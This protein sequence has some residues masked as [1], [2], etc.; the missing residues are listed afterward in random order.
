[1]NNYKRKDGSEYIEFAIVTPLRQ[2]DGTI[3]HYV[4]V[5]EDITEKKRIGQELDEY[6]YHL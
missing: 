6:R 4:A 5:K 2:P 3:S 1:M